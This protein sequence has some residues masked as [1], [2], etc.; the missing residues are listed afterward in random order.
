M[1]SLRSRL[2]ALAVLVVG[3]SAAVALP[4]PLAV[5]SVGLPL[6][7][8]LIGPSLRLE[9]VGQA[10]CSIIAALVGLL[11]PSILLSERLLHDI[12]RLSER[13]T[14]LVL[15]LLAVA[16]S[17]CLFRVDRHSLEGRRRARRAT[18]LTLATVLVALVAAGGALSGPVYPVMAAAFVAIAAAALSESDAGR[19]F[20]LRYSWRGTVAVVLPVL[21]GSSF[22]LWSHLTLPALNKVMLERLR[23]RMRYA[24][25]GFSDQL[26]LGSMVGML[27]DSSVVL[28]L[29]GEPAPELLRGVVFTSYAF[30]RWAAPVQRRMPVIVESHSERPSRAGALEIE[31]ARKPER[32]FLP[33]GVDSA[34]TS[35]GYYSRDEYR[36]FFP[37]EDDYAKRLWFQPG[38]SIQPVEPGSEELHVPTQLRRRLKGLLDAWGASTGPPEQRLAKIQRRLTTN[39]RYRLA[40]QSSFSA[41]PLEDFLFERHEGHCEYF[42]SAFAL[43]A[44]IAEVPT[45][46]VSGYRLVERSQFGYYIVR[47][48]HAHSW[49]EAWINGGWITFDPTPQA[50][51]AETARRTS[52]LGSMLDGISTEWEVLDDWLEARTALEFSLVLVVLVGAFVLVRLVRNRERK[53]ASPPGEEHALTGFTELSARLAAL[54]LRREPSET[55]HRFAERLEQTPRLSNAL[56]LDAAAAVRSYALLRYAVQGDGARID[57]ELL[58]LAELLS[59]R[60]SSIGPG[61]AC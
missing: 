40:S 22:A 28:R 59:S 48:H 38:G 14:L 44:R 35:S 27:N 4:G 37:P 26:D 18:R 30:G 16:S 12:H 41:T 21:L 24:R 56:A 11:L 9:R 39:Y 58:R 8:L 60:V 57:E 61:S 29:R 50:P 34:E 2:V 52:A 42:A 49:V 55:L 46:V 31:H 33:L 7:A 47:R 6:V 36:I 20:Q 17:R 25:V 10:V 5:A 23:E 45:R 43:L 53:G 32:Y 1:M 51:L 3:I 13:R 19:S 15:A 54:G